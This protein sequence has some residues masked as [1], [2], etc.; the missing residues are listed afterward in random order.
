MSTVLLFFFPTEIQIRLTAGPQA[1]SKLT[2]EEIIDAIDE[3]SVR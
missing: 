2:K 1:A 3:D